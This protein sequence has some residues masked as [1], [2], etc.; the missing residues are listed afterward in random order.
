MRDYFGIGVLKISKLIN[1]GNLLRSVNVFG[2]SFFCTE[3]AV[4]DTEQVVLSDISNVPPQS[5]RNETAA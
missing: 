3:N 4:F 1:L 5:A 2:A